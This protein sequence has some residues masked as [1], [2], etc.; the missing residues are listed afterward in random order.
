MRLDFYV[1]FVH[2]R[3]E[4]E[5]EEHG[6]P[7]PLVLAVVGREVEAHDEAHRGERAEQTKVPEE[8]VDHVEVGAGGGGQHRHGQVHVDVLQVGPDGGL[9]EGDVRAKVISLLYVS[10]KASIQ[11]RNNSMAIQWLFCT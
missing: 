1:M 10:D 3:E 6:G 4:G 9:A 2:T 5:P 8:G 7:L 11:F